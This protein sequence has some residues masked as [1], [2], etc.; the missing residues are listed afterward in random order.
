LARLVC[1]LSSSWIVGSAA[2]PFNPK[3]KD[4]DIAVPF[5]EWKK[6]GVCIPKEAR[7]TLFG[8][9]WKFI[10]DGTEVNIWPDDI[11]N[12]FQCAK[13]DWMWQ[14]IK[15][16]RIRRWTEEQPDNARLIAAAPELLEALKLWQRFWEDMPK[17]QLG[18]VVCN[19]GYLNDAFLKTSSAIAKTEK[20]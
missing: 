6:I 5:N 15:D 1:S 17:G 9:G 14:P 19:I 2:D 3:P 4:V 18:R 16:I 10:S 20:A 13:C 8:D 11:V 7:P 12:I